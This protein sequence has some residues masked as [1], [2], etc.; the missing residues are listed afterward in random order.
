MESSN[1]E[2]GFEDEECESKSSANW[3]NRTI[4]KI[5]RQNDG[6]RI[7]ARCANSADSD[8]PDHSNAPLSLEIPKVISLLIVFKPKVL[9]NA[10]KF[11]IK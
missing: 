6:F 5:I 2:A 8:V 10:M 1:A 3:L 9:R 11:A 4:S 7:L